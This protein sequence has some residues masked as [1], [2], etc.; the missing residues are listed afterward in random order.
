LRLCG[1]VGC[2]NKISSSKQEFVKAF[3]PERSY[4]MSITPEEKSI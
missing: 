1:R 4:V 3:K 2:L